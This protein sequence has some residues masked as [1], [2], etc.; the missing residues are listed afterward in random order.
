MDTIDRNLLAAL[1]TDGRASI[2]KLAD[3]LK[4]SRGTV[5]NRIDRL[6]ADGIIAG[7]TVRI[8]AAEDPHAVRAIMLIEITG[9]KTVPLLKTLRGVPEIRA[10]H[11]TNGAWDLVAEIQTENLTDFD[12]VLRHIRALEGVS[13]SETSLLLTT[14]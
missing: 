3:L 2:S 4:I 12:R 5:Q 1:R 10:L 8:A 11:T 13:K 9:Q 14:I 7:F 6:T